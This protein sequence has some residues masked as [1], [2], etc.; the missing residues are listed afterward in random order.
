MPHLTILAAAPFPTLT[1]PVRN[2]LFVVHGPTYMTVITS[3]YKDWGDLPGNP[4]S[5]PSFVA[6]YG[7]VV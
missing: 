2:A 6:Q 1:Q 4:G 7:H 5:L 3:K